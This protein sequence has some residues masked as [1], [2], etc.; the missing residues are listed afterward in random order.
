MLFLCLILYT[1]RG[2]GTL[3][4]PLRTSAWEATSTRILFESK[5]FGFF[6]QLCNAFW[7]RFFTFY[8]H[9]ILI[10]LLKKVPW[11]FWYKDKIFQRISQWKYSMFS[12]FRPDPTRRIAKFLN[13]VL[14]TPKKQSFERKRSTL[15][16][17]R[18]IFLFFSQNCMNISLPLTTN[19]RSLI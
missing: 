4:E 2:A 14:E 18:C 5:I 11:K 7:L 1:S 9:V 3:D 6:Y 17:F 12:I 15:I 19:S 10:I 13:S 16:Y 8:Y